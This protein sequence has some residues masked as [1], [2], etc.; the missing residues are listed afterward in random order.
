MESKPPKVKTNYYLCREKQRQR[1]TRAMEN[2][3]QQH[4]LTAFL[5]GQFTTLKESDKTQP[6]LVKSGWQ[7]EPEDTCE[8][9]ANQ[10]VPD[11][12]DY[13]FCND[14][15]N[16]CVAFYRPID[17]EFTVTTDGKSHRA[18]LKELKLYLFPHHIVLFSIE[19]NYASQHLNDLT[20]LIRYLRL[21]HESGN[22]EFNEMAI[23][24][25]LDAYSLL[26]GKNYCPD[27]HKLIEHG[28]KMRL[29]QII[30]SPEELQ[31]T[32]SQREL[33]LYQL[34][35]LA[36][37]VNPDKDDL[38]NVSDSYLERMMANNRVSVFKRWMA[39]ALNDT[40][41]LHANGDK[42]NF[43]T[44]WRGFFRLLYT[45]SLFQKYYL[46]GLN[47][48]YHSTI[49]E[50]EEN[51][52]KTFKRVCRRRVTPIEALTQE[53]Q[54]YNS[55]GCFNRVSYNF[56]PL[57]IDRAID[58]GL[59]V[60]DEQQQLNEML[61]SSHNYIQE[62]NNAQTK[63]LLVAISILTVFS[64]LCDVCDL[65]FNA[66]RG[67]HSAFYKIV[68]TISIVLLAVFIAFFVRKRH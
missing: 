51:W 38:D 65:S 33:T 21:M 37:E 25:L 6:L 41:T 18:Q 53:F 16:G 4:Q 10:Y 58:R 19:I 62:R 49:V 2:K 67:D 57:E 31:L 1:N 55:H 26:D 27:P 63:A 60:N 66:L 30:V 7:R 35:S 29:F 12:I 42:N 40:F 52:W 13:C 28:N 48:R 20:S 50:S 59:E 34:G 43:M 15:K 44:E 8:V 3:S 56:L 39:L 64:A 24:P 23:E 45:H 32:D 47:E 68:A 11:F 36:H 5:C 46:S 14:D 17:K 61:Q 54:I 22:D 9:Y